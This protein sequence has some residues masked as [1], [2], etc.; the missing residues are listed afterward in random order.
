M[1]RVIILFPLICIFSFLYAQ[2][3]SSGAQDS[4][5]SKVPGSVFI[6]DTR[7]PSV[8]NVYS[9]FSGTKPQVTPQHRLQ[10]RSYQTTAF[11][12]THINP[13]R[14]NYYLN[15]QLVTQFMDNPVAPVAAADLLGNVPVNDIVTLDIFKVDKEVINQ[16]LGVE[17][18]KAELKVL[19]DKLSEAQQTLGRV[20]DSLNLLNITTETA[21]M[22]RDLFYK[23]KRDQVTIIATQVTNK[24]SDLEIMLNKMAINNDNINFLMSLRSALGQISGDSGLM[25]TAT[26]IK[27]DIENYQ[28]QDEQLSQIRIQLQDLRTRPELILP[29]SYSSFKSR[30]ASSATYS[31]DFLKLLDKVGYPTGRLRDL[32]RR[33][34]DQS[35]IT[36]MQTEIFRVQDYLTD[37]K[38]SSLSGLLIAIYLELGKQL[39]DSYTNYSRKINEIKNLGYIDDQELEE[40]GKMRDDINK[41]FELIQLVNAHTSVLTLYMQI[42]DVQSKDLG[43]KIV[44]LYKGLLNFLKIADYVCKSSTSKYTLAMHTNSSNVDLIRYTVTEEDVSTKK[45]QTYVYDV[46]L[47]GGLKIDFSAGIFATGL[48]DREYEK[49]P[50]YNADTISSTLFNIKRKDKGN[51]GFA[52]GGM[53]NISPRLG[54][55]WFVPGI[56]VGVAYASNQK[57]QFL[58]G[59]SLHMGKTERIILHFGAAMGVAQTLDNSRVVYEEGSNSVRGNMNDYNIP[60]VD[61]FTAQYHFGISY[62]LSKKNA[63]QAVS[64]EGLTKF[65]SEMAK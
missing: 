54:T 51:V 13:L 4:V 49:S 11:R 24:L 23:Q 14:F 57:L 46:W 27:Q 7:D 37:K 59:G 8:L 6:L 35:Y 18:A 2:I 21:R 5:M 45:S 26:Q 33:A 64:G 19:Q 63:L 31:T 44:S 53:V 36:D 20:F 10:T 43:N 29:E 50:V 48:M 30:G 9:N 34:A 16:K 32:S 25:R 52:F 58:A 1:K 42:S 55:S 12:I 62:N 56:S 28:Q 41:N 65:N 47:K 15:G 22:K 40:V 38:I 60:T 61:K 3:P 39:Q 17:N